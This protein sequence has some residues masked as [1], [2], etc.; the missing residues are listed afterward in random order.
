M[1]MH[2]AEF[3]AFFY[4][5]EGWKSVQCSQAGGRNADVVDQLFV[6]TL[7][8]LDGETCYL[9]AVNRA[10]QSRDI[11]SGAIRALDTSS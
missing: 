4:P 7:G 6:V 5:G 2:R 11:P 1:F 9:I 10:Y 8:I 3:R